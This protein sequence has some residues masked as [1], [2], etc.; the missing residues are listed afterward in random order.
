MTGR[1]QRAMLDALASGGSRRW[2]PVDAFEEVCQVLDV[3]HAVAVSGTAALHLALAVLG[4]GVGDEV[5]VST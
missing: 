5:W 4:V 2:A 1:R 3:S